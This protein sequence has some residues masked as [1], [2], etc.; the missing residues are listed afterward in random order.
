MWVAYFFPA[1]LRVR[2]PDAT[3]CALILRSSLAAVNIA[4][5][6]ALILN[7]RTHLVCPT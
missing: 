1:A 5:S 3:L 7:N 6:D 4:V 2:V